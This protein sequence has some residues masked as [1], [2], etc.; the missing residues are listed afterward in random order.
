MFALLNYQ[1]RARCL[2]SSIIKS[3]QDVCTPQLSRANES[4]EP[5]YIDCHHDLGSLVTLWYVIKH[6]KL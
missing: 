6:D 4:T 1:E 3:E 5:L 2:H